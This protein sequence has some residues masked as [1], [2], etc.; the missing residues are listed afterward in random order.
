MSELKLKISADLKE[1]MKAK[2][3]T[4][5]GAIRMLLAAI[6]TE[7]TEGTKH[8][9]TDDEVLKIIAREIKKRR[10]SAEIYT[11][12][13]REDLAE[14]E[15]SEVAVLEDYQPE[16][17]SDE[18]V[19]QLIDAAVAETGATSMKEMGQVMKL[20]TEK[21]AGRADGKRLSTAVRERLA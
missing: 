1:A 15:L 12:N 11:Q 4:R 10:E 5:V 13:N 9:L 6:Q 7:E 19:A 17:L 14:T 2:D 8:E 21:A 20:A 16:Q 18:E 3:K